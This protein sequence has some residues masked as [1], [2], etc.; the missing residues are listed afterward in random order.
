MDI[1]CR[2]IYMLNREI[3]RKQIV[4]TYL[5]LRNISEVARLWHTSRNVVRKWITRFE[6]EGEEGLKDR[7]R[8]PLFT[9]EDK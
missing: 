3:A 5:A 1:S 4:N 7:S 6:E 9:W 2:E 8:K